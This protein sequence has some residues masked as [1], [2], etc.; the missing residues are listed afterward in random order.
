MMFLDYFGVFVWIF[1]KMDK[2]RK[3]WAISGVLRRGV[4]IP[5]SNVGPCQGLVCP[6]HDVAERGLR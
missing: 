4:G 6:C 5:H 2:I 3:I 1:G